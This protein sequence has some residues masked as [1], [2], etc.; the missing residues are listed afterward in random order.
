MASFKKYLLLLCVL[1]GQSV[2]AQYRTDVSL[3]QL[4][5]SPQVTSLKSYVSDI[6]DPENKGRKAGSEG[7]KKVAYY[8]Y[9][10]FEKAGVDLL[11]G[12]EGDLFGIQSEG[13]TLLSRNVAAFIPGSDEQLRHRYIVIAARMDNLGS[14]TMQVDGKAQEVIYPGANGNASGL[15]SLLALAKHISDTRID[16][17]KS[18]L[19]VAFGASCESFA[20]SWYFLN[21]SFPSVKDIDLMINL[22]MLGLGS[23]G[24]YAYT[25]SNRDLNKALEATS[26]DLQPVKPTLV[27]Q[28]D[29]P[30]DHRA[31]YAAEIPSVW[32]HSGRYSQH[33]TPRDTPDILD[34]EQM[35]LQL[36]YIYNFVRDQASYVEKIDFVEPEVVEQSPKNEAIYAYY[37]C[38]VPPAFLGS[39]RID[40]FMQEWV[41]RYVKYPESAVAEGVQG[42]VHVNFVVEKDGSVS[43]VKVVRSLDPRLDQAAQDVVEISPKWKAARLHGQKVRSSL[44][45]PIEFRLIKK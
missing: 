26:R 45:I 39:T 38:D 42:I 31:F 41:Y 2:F 20:G 30:S 27:A 29:Y 28:E 15:A 37:D 9:D 25:A 12:R 18:I 21:R 6:C 17:R 34:W 11:Y 14:Y 22:D 13:D 40:K 1:A 43:Q 7:E 33:N 16:F 44:T 5:D 8:L 32:F 36:E 4:Y 19:F 3:E 23:K 35:E 24:F 10:A